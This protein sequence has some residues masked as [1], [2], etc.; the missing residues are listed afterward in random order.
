[1]SKK[2]K[3]LLALVLATITYCTFAQSSIRDLE[4][5]MNE[6]RNKPYAPLPESV[7]RDENSAGK[8]LNVLIPYYSDTLEV[9]RSKAYYITKRIGQR[10]NDAT[11][12][13]QAVHYLV[14]GIRDKDSGISGNASE[15]LAGFN[16]ENFSLVDKDSIGQYVR[17]ETAHVDLVLKLAGYLELHNYQQRIT[18]I[19]NSGLGFKYTWAGRLALAR[20]GDR[21][22]VNYILTKLSKAPVSDNLVYDVV[23][24]LVYTR[25]PEIFKYLETIINSNQEN[26]QSADPD[27]NKKIICG[28]RVMEHIA[29]AIE[30]YPVPVDESG[31]LVT[32][33]YE[34]S[35]NTVRAWLAQHRS[36]TIRTDLY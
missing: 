8:L 17:P 30:N 13:Q 36:Y 4:Q 32:N 31:E 26:C 19:V 5:Y 34:A 9:M 21:E 6:V 2:M 12:R 20:M 11:V 18:S 16:K 1:M 29:T 10:S 3:F 33:D 7:L 27:S 14:L 15:A 35:L 25:Q 23:P 28:Y 22:S 24:D